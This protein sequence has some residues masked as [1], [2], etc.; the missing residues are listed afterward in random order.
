MIYQNMMI[1]SLNRTFEDYCNASKNNGW[2]EMNHQNLKCWNDF[3]DEGG[4]M[5]HFNPNDI[6]IIYSRIHN[7]MLLLY[8]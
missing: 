1:D 8:I 3:V 5:N 4:S 7:N 6:F 2:I